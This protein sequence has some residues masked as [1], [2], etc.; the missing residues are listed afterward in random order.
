MIVRAGESCD[1]AWLA[2]IDPHIPPIE[3]E[4]C[5]AAGEYLVD[6]QCRG[7]LRYA[8]FWREIPY[9]ELIWVDKPHRGQG[10]GHAL[11]TRWEHEMRGRGATLLLTSAMADEPEPQRWHVSGGYVRCGELDF[12]RWQ[13][14]G[15]VFF[16]KQLD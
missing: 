1:V 12:G 7:F 9:M 13:S 4:R 15:E 14:V 16:R 10:I 6:S 3:V 11:R 2:S 5:I 8:M